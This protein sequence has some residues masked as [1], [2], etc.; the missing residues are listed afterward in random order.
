MKLA[1]IFAMLK[2][3]KATEYGMNMIRHFSTGPYLKEFRYVSE[4]GW[5]L[6]KVHFV[7][8]IFRVSSAAQ[9]AHFAP[10]CITCALLRRNCVFS[11]NCAEM[12]CLRV[13]AQKLR[14]F[15]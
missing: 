5:K 14:F 1:Q 6:L 2:G 3:V 10:K 15:L 8:A 7:H 11:L 13:T 9:I 4:Y 12:H